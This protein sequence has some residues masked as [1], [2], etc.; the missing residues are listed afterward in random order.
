MDTQNLQL[1]E[2]NLRL[3]RQL[4]AARKW[5]SQEVHGA[6]KIINREK[7]QWDTH[8][9]YHSNLEDIISERIYSF[10]PSEVLSYFPSD[11]IKNI[12]SSELIYYHIIHGWHVDGTWVI[13]WYQKVLDGMIELYITKWFRK[14]IKKYKLS[15]PPKNNPLEKAFHSV[16]EK[17]Y[18]LSLGRL[19]AVLK[20][21]HSQKN[22][23]GY[24]QYFSEYLKSRPFLQKALLESDFLLQ[25]ESLTH[26]HATWEKRHHGSLSPENTQKAR[27][28]CIG[29]FTD[30]D[31][32]L[33]ILAASQS[34]E[35]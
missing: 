2:E 33:Y 35:L 4:V 12:L 8:S 21:I 34:V 20:D 7:T 15:H 32:L 6:Q 24:S 5:M 27:N 19:Y 25:L 9:L 1:Q 10:F 11:G 16:I 14:Y 29:N 22:L 28:L 18:I 23:S 26:L 30:T 17:N 31:C 13:I 3:K